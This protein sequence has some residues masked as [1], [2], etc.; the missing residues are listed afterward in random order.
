MPEVTPLTGNT[1]VLRVPNAKF[2]A[3]RF[4][5][6][7]PFDATSNPEIA[8]PVKVPR[9]VMLGCEGW[10]TELAVTTVPIIELE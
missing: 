4:E 5:I 6:P 2:D 1:P 10:T 7:E 8:R 9:L 3:L